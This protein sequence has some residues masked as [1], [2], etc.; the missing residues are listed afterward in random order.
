MLHNIQFQAFV[1]ILFIATVVYG[2]IY[3]Y[4]KMYDYCCELIRKERIKKIIPAMYSEVVTTIQI[5]KSANKLMRNIGIEAAQS[6]APPTAPPTTQTTT[7]K[8]NRNKEFYRIKPILEAILP[9]LFDYLIDTDKT[10][11]H[12]YY[13]L[14]F[15][16]TKEYIIYRIAQKIIDYPNLLNLD[17]KT[18]A[19]FY[20][21]ERNVRGEIYRLLLTIRN[22]GAG[23]EEI[24]RDANDAYS[25]K[26]LSLDSKLK[27]VDNAG[28]ERSLYDVLPSQSK[29]PLSILIQ[30]QSETEI[31]AIEQATIDKLSEFEKQL[32]INEFDKKQAEKKGLLFNIESEYSENDEIIDIFKYRRK[33]KS[34]APKQIDLF[35]G[36][37]DK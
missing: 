22:A 16:D 32:L 5:Q 30:I 26:E 36:G 12:L 19:D 18:P 31:E 23:A 29:D 2:E 34:S 9:A 8:F 10:D 17:F 35:K 14:K 28:K 25:R 13:S 3:S 37:D 11:N 21:F 7:Q 1:A 20:K 24:L 15:S 6:N 4:K 33:P 27:T